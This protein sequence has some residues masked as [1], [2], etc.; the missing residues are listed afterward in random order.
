MVSL[1][2][3]DGEAGWARNSQIPGLVDW[4]HGNR[5]ITPIASR[6]PSHLPRLMLGAGPGRQ[7]AAIH[8]HQGQG[9]PDLGLKYLRHR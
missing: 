4:R 7:V 9:L 1:K 5:K 2:N 3:G 6:P 8:V